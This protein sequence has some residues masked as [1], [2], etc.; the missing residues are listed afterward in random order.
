MIIICCG[1][2]QVIVGVLS[3]VFVKDAFLWHA[4]TYIHW[5][6]ENIGLSSPFLQTNAADTRRL[7]SRRVAAAPNVTLR[8]PLSLRSHRV[9]VLTFYLF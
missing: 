4:V 5:D 8:A 1:W 3:I 9:P 6:A 2:S 7:I